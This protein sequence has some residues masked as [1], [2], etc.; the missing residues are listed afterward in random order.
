MRGLSNSSCPE[1]Y[2]ESND[3]KNNI[4]RVS[5]FYINFI[6]LSLTKP[7]PVAYHMVYHIARTISYGLDH[8]I[9]FCIW[10]ISYGIPYG[11]YHMVYH[12]VSI[13]WPN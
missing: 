4:S 10:S 5:R 8:I 2:F 6:K 7:K 3:F 1:K 12:M 9:G 13:I 11:L